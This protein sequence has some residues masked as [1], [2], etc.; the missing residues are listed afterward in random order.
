MPITAQSLVRRAFEI[1]QDTTAVRW[2]TNE[3]VRWLNDAQREVAM[4]R[5]D[6]M[7]TN[8]TMTCV[9]GSKQAIPSGG[10]KLINVVR[11]AAG[12]KRAVR[13]VE[14]EILDSQNP[15]WH[16][17]AG[18]A[19]VVHYM[20]DARDPKTFYVYPPAT[21]TATLDIVYSALPAD[22]S[23]PADGAEYTAVSGN[24]SIPE[25][26]ANAALDYMLYRAYSK[27]SQFAGNA[28]R[29]QAHYQAFANSMGVEVKG[30]IGSA[31]TLPGSIL[32]PN[33]ARTLPTAAG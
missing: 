31:P 33:V 3:L 4:Y 29:A 30:L 13:L 7:S 24:I 1:L 19:E 2:P 9:A 23:E 10:T 6:S 20:F 15:R 28:Q 22:V 32:N 17:M 5:P 14:R 21:N 11:N 25:I 16:N 27:D 18:N 8:A 26:F 12:N